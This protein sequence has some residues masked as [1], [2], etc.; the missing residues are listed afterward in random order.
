MI[1]SADR[2]R[3]R[4][5][6]IY[7][8]SKD[9][10]I[11]RAPGR[12]NL[13]G[14]HT[15]YN[16]GFVLPIALNLGIIAAASPRKDSKIVLYS[17][18]FRTYSSFSL[19]EKINRDPE[20]T[21][22]NYP[23]GVIRLLKEK[24]YGLNGM[25][26]FYWGDMPLEGGLSSSAAIE[27]ATAFLFEK[28]LNLRIDP[29]EMIKLCQHA[30]NE[31]VGVGCGI[32][33]QFIVRLAQKGHAIFLNC[34]DLSY[35]Q[36]PFS[37]DDIKIVICNTMVKRNL[38]DSAYNDRR[39]ECQ[40]GVLKRM[41]HV[42][43]ENERVKKSVSLL[44]SFDFSSF[45]ECMYES[46]RSL[47]DDYEVSCPELDLMVELARRIKGTLG[48]RMTGAGFGGCTV[49]LVADEFIDKFKEKVFQGYKKE[50][51]ISPEI[52]ISTAEDGVNRIG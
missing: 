42:N 26:I 17:E 3:Q 35:E 14:E 32:M 47:R 21:W 51:G 41:R 43:S 10:I 44:K 18:N 2:V 30:E 40:E 7:P 48:A 12:I 20:V 28:Y 8:S 31:F 33:D 1:L 27:I 29:L 50:T 37:T 38:K 11:V 36:V 6:D 4:F 15:D 39:R 13:I 19:N 24:G 34:S 25:N 45:G 9:I 5:L 52:Y 23:R 16:G 46:H 49:N 22:A